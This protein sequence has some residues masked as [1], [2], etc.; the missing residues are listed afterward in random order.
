VEASWF[1]AATAYASLD[2]H[3]SNDFA[4]YVFKTTDY[5]QTWTSI[6]SNLPRGNVRS[7]RQ[8]PVN[9][10]LL[11]AATEFGFYISLDDGK[12]WQQ[13]MPGLPVGRVDEIVVHPRDGDLILA[14]HGRGIYVMDDITSLQ[15]MAAPTSDGKLF[16]PRD[17][18]DWKTDYRLGARLPGMK[19][20]AG[21][22]APRGT[23]IAYTLPAAAP[24]GQVLVTITNL[25]SG[26]AVKTCVGTGRAGLNRFQWEMRGDAAPGGRGGGTEAAPAGPTPCSADDGGGGRGG[27]GGGGGGGGGINPGIYQ[28]KVTVAGRE[29]G[30]ETFSILEDI[31]MK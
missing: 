7:I 22:N 12:A 11:Y 25:A 16:K 4:P 9:A 28:V 19:G 2:G 24:A 1:D 17:A 29:I 8:D 23:A 18:V 13:F 26:A 30:A 10:N 21:E 20:F 5:G 3:H 6:S 27:R 14:S 15:Q 31:W